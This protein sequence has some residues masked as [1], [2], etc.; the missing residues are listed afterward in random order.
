M[1]NYELLIYNQ[2]N[3]FCMINGGK[4]DIVRFEMHIHYLCK[5]GRCGP[6]CPLALPVTMFM[7]E[8]VFCYYVKLYVFFRLFYG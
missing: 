2:F 7:G 8:R 3:N 6:K 1:T 4:S 5:N